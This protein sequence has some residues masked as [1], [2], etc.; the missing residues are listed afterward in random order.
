MQNNNTFR[1]LTIVNTVLIVA[2][3]ILVSYF[4]YK[5][6]IYPN[7]LLK[8]SRKQNAVSKIESRDNARKATVKALINSINIYKVENGKCPLS[9]EDLATAEKTKTYSGPLTKKPYLYST[10]NAKCIVS[11]TLELSNDKDLANDYNPTNSPVYELA[12]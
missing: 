9:L 12:I 4:T 10:E 1:L 7:K 2:P 6:V 3:L 11:A 5:L 8:S